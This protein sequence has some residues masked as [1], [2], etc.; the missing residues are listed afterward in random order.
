ME[1]YWVQITLPFL[2]KR[3]NWAPLTHYL[4]AAQLHYHADVIRKRGYV[5]LHFRYLCHLWQYYFY[6]CT[7]DEECLFFSW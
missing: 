6:H 7:Y 4:I 3:M 1:S 5:I 2:M